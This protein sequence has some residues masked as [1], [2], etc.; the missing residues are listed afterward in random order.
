[1]STIETTERNGPGFVSVDDNAEPE[2]LVQFL[3]YA[4][5][6]AAVR[7]YKE[8]A[9]A[10][11]ALTPGAHVLD[12]GC[13]AGDDL[14][15]LAA[16]VGPDGQVVGV[17]P[18]KV[19]LAHARTKLAGVAERCTLV[20]ASASALPFPDASFDAVRVD[21]VLH[22]VEQPARAIAEL[23]RVTRPGGRVVVSEPDHDTIVLDTSEPDLTDRLLSHRRE[24]GR[25]PTPG[26]LLRRLLV[27]AGLRQVEISA[28]TGV[29]TNLALAD[30]LL[31]ITT[32]L[33]RAVED[34]ALSLL[35]A[36]TWRAG[37]ARETASGRFLASMTVFTCCGVRDDLGA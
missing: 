5:A 37:A 31:G 19:M 14:L 32:W 8:H 21:R 23:R 29:I 30:A 1:M 16:S 27:D 33:Q 7:A 24:R 15:A 9:H 26:R 25:L 28:H 13:G 10:L 36:M 3:E 34:G 18:S 20:E 2:R 35:E 22:F 12:V 11:L 4:S 6:Q 17:D